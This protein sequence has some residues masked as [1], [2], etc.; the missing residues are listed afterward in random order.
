MLVFFLI[1]KNVHET[2]ILLKSQSD[3]DDMLKELQVIV[4]IIFLKFEMFK[5]F[6]FQ[7]NIVD[8]AK[9][10]PLVDDEIFHMPTFI[11]STLMTRVRCNMDTKNIYYNDFRTNN[12][13]F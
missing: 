3:P 6:Y 9:N 12:H 11:A 7:Q 2:Q 10:I 4:Y 13:I 8:F 5:L 1:Q